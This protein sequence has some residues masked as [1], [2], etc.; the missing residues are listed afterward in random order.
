M[1]NPFSVLAGIDI[2]A[3]EIVTFSLVIMNYAE[4]IS[5]VVSVGLSMV[6]KAEA[7]SQT[8]VASSIY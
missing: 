1:V 3:G 5:M 6:M 4:S 8:G 2:L 7:V